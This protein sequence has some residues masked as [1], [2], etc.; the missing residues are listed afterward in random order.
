MADYILDQFTAADDTLI[1]GRTTET[2][3]TWTAQ[4]SG[5]KV[6]SNRAICSTD[7]VRSGAADYVGAWLDV[8]EPALIRRLDAR[9]RRTGQVQ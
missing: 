1:H 3:E 7:T 8:L 4:V 6:S 2:G 5:M 9:G